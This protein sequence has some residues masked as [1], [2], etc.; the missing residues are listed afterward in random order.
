MSKV[1]QP[2]TATRPED[3]LP[4]EKIIDYHSEEMMTYS[5]NSKPNLET[6]PL[7]TLKA[8]QEGL[9]EQFFIK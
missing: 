2:M 6:H 1:H 4:F 7:K 5:F 3:R 8:V 9:E